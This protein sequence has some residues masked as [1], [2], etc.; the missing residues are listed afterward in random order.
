[1]VI[2]FPGVDRIFL[3][4]PGAND[5]FGATDVDSAALRDAKLFHFGYPTLMR[6]MY[7]HGGEELEALFRRAKQAGVTTSLDMAWVEPSSEA[8]QVD[9]PAVLKR[10]L[11]HVDVFLP[12]FDE[13]LYMADRETFLSLQQA[14]AGNVL[15]QADG[16]L[17]GQVAQKLLDLGAAVA[18]L[19]LGDQGLYLRATTDKARLQAMGPCAPKDLLAWSGCELL[20]PCFCVNVAGTT[21]S[22]DCTIAGVLAGLLKGLGPVETII[23][24]VAAGAC[25]VEAPDAVSGVRSWDEMQARI[26]AGWA[27]RDVTLPLDGWSFDETAGVYNTKHV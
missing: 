2:N 3:H 19:K 18:V 22:G 14:G 5:T 15:G 24:G 16:D 7:T 12:S 21:G 11:P 26:A 1:V 23:A 9:W 25:N 10:L 8:G 17:I 4:C 6:R 27:R 13:I 20:A